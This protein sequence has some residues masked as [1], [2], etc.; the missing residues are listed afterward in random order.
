MFPESLSKEN[1]KNVNDEYAK[2]LMKSNCVLPHGIEVLPL[3]L[4]LDGTHIS[5]PMYTRCRDPCK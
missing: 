2:N 1:L 3:K 5:V 4:S